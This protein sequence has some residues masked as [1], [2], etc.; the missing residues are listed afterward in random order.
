[1]KKQEQNPQSSQAQTAPLQSSVPKIAIIHDAFLYRGGGERLV[2]LMAKSLSADIITGFFSEWSFDPR[3]LGFTGKMIA[4]GSPVFAKGIRHM[5]LKWRFFWKARIL[6]EYDIVIFS[7]DCLGAMRHVRPDAEKVYY[8]HTP[9]RYLYDFREKYL[10]SLPSIFRPIFSMAFRIFASIYESHLG[11]FDQIFT[12]SKNVQSRLKHFTGY[13]SVIV[14]PPVDTDRFTPGARGEGIT[15]FD[16]YYLSWA[17][18]SPPKRV[19]LIIEAFLDMPE[20]N[21]IFTYGKND[22]LKEALL[23]KIEWISN[24]LAIDSPDDNTLLDLIR[25]AVATIYIPIDED[26]GMTPVESMACGIPVIG[27]AEW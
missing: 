25:W 22:P 9:P 15:R 24:R 13:D 16:E 27:A 10:L 6:R 11:S 14:Y 3:E 8:C 17:R 7:W 20:K 19:D 23:K 12:N 5:I 18:L 2:T 1:M 21:L 4:L 26:F